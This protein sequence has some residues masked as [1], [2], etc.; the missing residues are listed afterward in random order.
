MTDHSLPSV[1]LSDSCL[2]E[3][4]A[5]TSHAFHDTP[6]YREM[7]TDPERR[8][9]FLAWLFERNVWLKLGSGTARC[10]YERKAGSGGGCGGG[11]GSGNGG[12]G[13]GGGG[14]EEE[15]EEEGRELV[16]FFMLEL[17]DAA[18]ITTWDMLRAGLLLGGLVHGIGTMRR[19]VRTKAWL[20]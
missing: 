20:G 17:P 18:Q 10:V 11:G 9:G 1:P 2:A 7:V 6:S 14:E 5:L 4:V 8:R 3:A 13:G 12:S 19:M 15:E 16:M